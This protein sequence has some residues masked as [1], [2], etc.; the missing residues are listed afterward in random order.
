[1]TTLPL[2]RQNKSLPP[3]RSYQSITLIF[4]FRPQTECPIASTMSQLNSSIPLEQLAEHKTLQSLW[5]AVHGY[6]KAHTFPQITTIPG[7]WD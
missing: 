4:S 6:G 1:M 5:I 7:N 2:K 3:L